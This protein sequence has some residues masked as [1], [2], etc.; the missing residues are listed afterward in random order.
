[1]NST[2]PSPELAAAI[3]VAEAITGALWSESVSPDPTNLTEVVDRLA[4]NTK[5]VARAI[6]PPHAGTGAA[7][8]HVGSLTEAV[9][10]VAAGL[11]QIAD[12]IRLLA[13]VTEN[14]P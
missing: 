7:G 10:D 4:D 1:M 8:T 14:K 6:T 3:T 12:A 11:V 9:M 5:L 2:N 13:E